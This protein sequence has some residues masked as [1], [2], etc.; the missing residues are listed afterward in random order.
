MEKVTIITNPE[1]YN[2]HLTIQKFPPELQRIYYY[3]NRVHSFAY[4][5]RKETDTHI[6]W[7]S[8]ER[9]P[10]FENGRFFYR[11]KALHGITYDRKKKTTKIWFG[12]HFNKL[13]YAMKMDCMNYLAP[14]VIKKINTS[15]MTLV[16]NTMFSKM[17]NGKINNPIEFIEA[18]L[19]TSPYKKMDIDVKL[20][21]KVFGKPNAYQSVKVFKDLLL[22]ADDPN[23]AL[24]YIDSTN[25]ISK[26]YLH[27][28]AIL[29]LSG[30]ANML[31][32]KID[33]NMPHKKA[34]ALYD[35]LKK[36]VDKNIIIYKIIED[37]N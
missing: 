3:S 6:Y 13:P 5:S 21:H 16:N 14:W 8:V 23:K 30:V 19:K 27:S 18:Y 24:K 33:V 22:C 11:R 32:V 26:Q 2:E 20:F 12:H 17:M 1:A 36:Q 9:I 35:E 37:V 34:V 10:M 7:S 25:M 15:L 28:D 4:E 31:G 29:T